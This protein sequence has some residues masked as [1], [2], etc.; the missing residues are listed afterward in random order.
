MRKEAFSLATL[1]SASD[2][3]LKP[4]GTIE[5]TE[6]LETIA[7]SI[8]TLKSDQIALVTITLDFALDGRIGNNYPDL[9]NHCARSYLE[10]LRSLVRWTDSVFLHNQTYYFILPGANL[11]GGAI[12]QERLWD[13][14]LWR[15]NNTLEGNYL[16]PYRISIGHSACSQPFI[17]VFQYIN[18]AC[19]PKRSFDLQPGKAARRINEMS[20]LN[21]LNE[22]SE[23]SEIKEMELPEL[24]RRL[25]VPYVSFLPRKLPVRLQR[26]VTP[27]LAQELCCFPIGRDR[28]ILTVAMSNP[29]DCRV[30]DR[31]RKETGLTIFPV[32][33]HPHELQTVLEQFS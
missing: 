27:M 7:L 15:I 26:L 17:D 4:V 30:L 32:L 9:A 33:A 31:L 8:H 1:E 20:E 23:I 28:D 24:A 10:H 2:E 18:A 29:Q 13:A 14:L 5:M 3:Y 12:V 16:H 22:I 6:T 19:E 25:G 21:E 11:Q